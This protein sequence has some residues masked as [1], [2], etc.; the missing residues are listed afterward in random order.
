[1]PHRILLGDEAVALGAIHAGITSAYAYPGTP[2]TEILEFILDHRRRHGHPHAAW[3]ANEKTAY[4]EAL[5]A[6]FAGRRALVSMKHV[7]L[8]VAA[9]A[10]VNSA[11]LG[12]HA[13]LVLAVADDP[14][15]HS[16]QNEQ[17]SRFYADFARVPCLEPADQQEA[18][19]MTREAFD[20][21][22]RFGVPLMVRLVTRLAHSRTDVEIG[23]PRGENPVRKN[24]DP[25]SWILLP[26]HARRRWVSLLARQGDFLAWS[27][28]CRWN[29]LRLNAARR[30]LGIITCGV[31][32]NYVAENLDDLGWVPSHL[33]IGAYP[34]PVTL[35]R[36]LAEHVERV[37]VIEDGQPLVERALRGLLPGGVPVSGRMDGTLPASGELTPDNV[38]EALGIAPRATQAYDPGPLPSR[39]PQLCEGCPHGHAFKAL[40]GALAGADPHLVTSDIGCYTLGALPPWNAIE[41]CVCMGASIG[42]A[43]G[44]AEAGF[45]PVVAVIGDSTFLHSGMT[46][47]LDAAAADTPMTLFILDNE[48]TAMTGGQE[49][50][51]PSSRLLEIVLGLGVPPAHCHVVDAHPR[52]VES[53]AALLRREIAHPGLSVV[54]A[55]RECK[56]TARRHQRERARA[57]AEAAATAGAPVSAI[58]TEEPPAILD[59]ISSGALPVADRG[60]VA[61]S[62]VMP[63]PYDHP[64]DAGG[65]DDAG[66]GGGVEE[67]VT[68]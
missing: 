10:F 7:G 26:A 32:R 65:G 53:N 47:L 64:S 34:L 51:V 5:G 16:S 67:E 20:R 31:A 50:L 9:D 41:S 42:M 45:Q 17:D 66:G 46:A 15:M 2:S 48:A 4:E 54:I 13:G 25:A 1:M 11:L 28:S 39:P 56:E 19:D 18:Y 35:V 62:R 40:K 14:G 36:R 8:N 6:C 3:S 21:S 43:K 59:E 23:E 30:D 49:P 55:V 22:E 24:G 58:A 60:P 33:H 61:V 68:R 63:D 12:L 44:A 38:R 37:L 29:T 27:E 52:R 57:A